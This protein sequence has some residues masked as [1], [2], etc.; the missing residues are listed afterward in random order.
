MSR[1]SIFNLG[2]FIEGFSLGVSK[3]DY[4]PIIKEFHSFIVKKYP[5]FEC[6][7]TFNILFEVA[8]H[9]ESK[10]FDLF[11]VDFEKF[12]TKQGIDIQHFNVKENQQRNDFPP[13]FN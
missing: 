9:D 10:A 3:E 2:D 11:F 12:L 6:L 8:D 1:K 13:S 5:K 7:D 4:T